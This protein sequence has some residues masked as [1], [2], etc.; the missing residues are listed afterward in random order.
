[1]VLAY[2]VVGILNVYL[3]C[4]DCDKM[5][6]IC[7]FPLDNPMEFFRTDL[8][9]EYL[10]KT[11]INLAISHLKTRFENY[12]GRVLAAR[13]TCIFASKQILDSI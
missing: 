10:K 2:F 13:V 5:L 3:F 7:L 4:L 6:K 11:G 9:L 1:M 12:Y 8:D